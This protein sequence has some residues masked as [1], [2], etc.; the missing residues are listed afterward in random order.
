MPA[1][2]PLCRALDRAYAILARQDRS[3]QELRIKL[4]ERGFEPEIIAEALAKLRS[5]GY[6]DDG[7]YLMNATR[8]LATTRGWG[9][10]KIAATLKGKGF[11][12][13][14]IGAALAEARS[15]MD[16]VGA[17]RQLIAKERR[18]TPEWDEKI[19]RRLFLRFVSCGFAPAEILRIMK[20]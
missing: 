2:D 7:R 3:E 19:K 12:R 13:E 8:R 16:E 15:E 10:R 1:D 5:Y 9:N 4:K 18:K 11:T 20:E 17:L 14:Q 6:L